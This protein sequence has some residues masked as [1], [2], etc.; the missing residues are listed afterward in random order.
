MK[1][2]R[3]GYKPRDRVL[4]IGEKNLILLDAKT[5]KVKH[6]IPF[7]KIPNIVVTKE[8]DNL[9]LIRIPSEL[10]KDKGDLILDIPQV[11]ECCIWIIT[12]SNNKNIIEIMDSA[13]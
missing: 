8:G 3:R 1:Y 13:S 4:I 6:K 10:K 11:I 5:Y 7:N 2:D 12:A 9:M